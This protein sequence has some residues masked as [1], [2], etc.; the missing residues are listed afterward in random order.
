M[1]LTIKTL[2]EVR[3]TSTHVYYL[4]ISVYFHNKNQL[5]LHSFCIAKFLQ[6]NFNFKTQHFQAYISV[7]HSLYKLKV[8][9]NSLVMEYIIWM[10]IWTIKV[11]VFFIANENNNKKNK[12]TNIVML[13][14]RWIVFMYKNRQFSRPLFHCC[15][16]MHTKTMFFFFL[17]LE[18]IWS[19]F[20]FY[21]SFY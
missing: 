3:C 7:G 12:Q 5:F 15:V 9:S 10:N 14:M 21:L 19:E 13:W 6:S 17:L 1:T 18:T 16:E 2:I 20:T 8:N 4:I 11:I